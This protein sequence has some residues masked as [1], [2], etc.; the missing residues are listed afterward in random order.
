MFVVAT[1]A[2]VLV[3]LVAGASFAT[4]AHRR[5]RQLGLLAAAGATPRHLRR[6]M[7]ANGTAVGL[8]A[9]VVGTGVGLLAWLA[10]ASALE[11]AAA[12]RIDRWNIPLWLPVAGIGLAVATATDR[13]VV[14]GPSRRPDAD[15]RRRRRPTA[16][17]PSGPPLPRRRRGPLRA[18]ASSRS[19]PAS[20]PAPTR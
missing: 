18:T 8:T 2:M 20:T 5:M 3:C 19:A 7:V 11:P 9:A 10:S 4:L 16:G 1:V 12:H 14:A 15:H 17:A 6:A 13:G